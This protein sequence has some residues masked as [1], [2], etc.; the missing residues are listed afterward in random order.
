MDYESEF[1]RL[2]KELDHEERVGLIFNVVAALGGVAMI[3]AP[4]VCY[5]LGYPF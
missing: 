1:Q 5:L 3:A 2:Q 4:G